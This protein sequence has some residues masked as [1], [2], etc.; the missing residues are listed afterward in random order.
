MV[1][2][3]DFDGTLC[4]SKWPEIGEPK[5]WL[6]NHLRWNQHYKGD[7]II[8]W[9][10]R[11]GELLDNAVNWAGQHGLHFDAINDNVQERIDKY[12]DNTRKVSADLYIDDRSD[13]PFGCR[14][15][16]VREWAWKRSVCKALGDGLDRRR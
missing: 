2:A 1:I 10:C 11:S 15:K 4:E 7:K 5:E 6:I 9:T 13:F 8:L 16:R 12:G 14:S 3:V